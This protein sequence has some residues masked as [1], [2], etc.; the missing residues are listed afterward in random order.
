MY[1]KEMYISDYK[2]LNDLKIKLQP[3]P[4]AKNIVNVIA[5]INGTGKTSLLESIAKG[6]AGFISP[7]NLSL[8]LDAETEKKRDKNDGLQK[9]TESFEKMNGQGP[10]LI[11]IASYLI[12]KFMPVTQLDTEY[13]FI[14]QLKPEEILGN[15][16]Y[17]IREY[18]LAH[19]RNSYESDPLKRTREAILNFN[20]YWKEA[21]ILTKLHDL[22]R[23]H[24]N[25]PVFKQKNNDTLV[26][27]DSLS[28]GER[29]LYGLIVALMILNPSDSIILIDEPELA[30][31]PAWQQII[32]S[33]YAK[34]GQNN[35]FIVAT[36]SPQ[37]IART[38][39]KNLVFL[40]KNK[41]SHKIEAMYPKQRPSGID[42]N[43][44]LSE[45]MGVDFI[46]QEQ[47][48]LHQKYRNFVEKHQEN[49][50]EAQTIKQQ[51][52][53]RESNTSEFMQ[54]MQF[55]IQLRGE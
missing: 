1:I 53:E 21:N 24:F 55:M 45:F 46:P 51:I 14:N 38:P 20:Q 52:L 40:R 39:I 15:A 5:G 35:Q 47:V 17:Y 30:L 34:I 4:K 19:E 36:H 7:E 33:I 44:I 11:Y 25:R 3:P 32:M 48:E 37:I 23:K 10:K 41:V 31:H 26:S 13:H 18:I 29:Q 50:P 2:I 9:I 27:I 42:I 6:F 28:D 43:S 16:E 12:D 8:T 49:L 22:D 54:E